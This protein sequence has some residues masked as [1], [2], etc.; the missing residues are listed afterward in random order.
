MSTTTE[1]N[2]P[3]LQKAR[4]RRPAADV[5]STTRLPPHAED[6]E[7]GVLG[8]ILLSPN[9][10]L[11]HCIEK[12]KAES[13][14]FYDLRHQTIY[15]EFLEMFENREAID[16]LTVHQRLKDKQQ[17]EQVGGI[18]YLNSLQE[19]VPS[20]A[21]IAYY[22]EI[23]HEK[24]V[25]RRLIQTCT[26]TVGQVYEHEGDV[27]EIMDN[28]ERDI[29]AIRQF[30]QTALNQS[31]PELVD[32]A[33]RK[34]EIYNDRKGELLGLSTGL[35]DLDKMTGGL[36]GG[37]MIIIAARPSMGKTSLAMNIAERNAVDMKIPVGVFSLEMTSESLIMR[38]ICSR[39]RVNIRNITDG[40]MAERDFGPITS[41]AGAIR[42][43]PLYIDGTSALS[44]MELRARA[45]RMVQEKGVKLLVVDYLQLLHGHIGKKRIENRQQE[46]SEISGGVKALAK[47]LNIPVI[48][49]SQLGR[50]LEK[51][52][53]KPMLHDLRESGSL[54][55]DGDAIFL[56]YRAIRGDDD[57]EIESDVCP[58]NVIIAKQRNGPVGE[59]NLTFLKSFTRFE[60]AA[61]VT[62][63]DL[64][65]ST[66]PI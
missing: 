34:I 15:G 24:Y 42:R 50:D 36:K 66:L 22:T 35:V 58:V 45:R 27:D 23:V 20:A 11:G 39:A 44:V 28:A 4:R 29:L 3:D 51:H 61:K 59:V 62:D 13:E 19:A 17:L 57:E 47:E 21:N 7:R 41:A 54:E 26:N 8:C 43:A 49:L 53:R 2:K 6:M 30:Q 10:C 55:Q 5:I 16:I 40:F 48:I 56:L 63:D 64:P 18:A 14:V 60:S 12:F 9:E 38:M 46:I 25:L 31:T 33:L 37:E 1:T 52:K 32:E 65:E